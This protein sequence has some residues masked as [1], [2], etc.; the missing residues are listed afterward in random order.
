MAGFWFSR[1]RRLVEI[2]SVR[3]HDEKLAVTVLVD[4]GDDC[5]AWFSLV[6]ARWGAVALIMDHSTDTW[7]LL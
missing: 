3:V 1:V 2:D 7:F 6:L 5:W 4:L